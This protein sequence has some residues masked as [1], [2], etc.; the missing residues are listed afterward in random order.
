MSFPV[1][2]GRSQIQGAPSLI[3]NQQQFGEEIPQHFVEWFSG[4]A[5]DTI[6]T[7]TITST[8]T[9]VM[10]DTVD[11]GVINTTA[12]TTADANQYCFNGIQHYSKVGNVMITVF[13]YTDNMTDGILILGII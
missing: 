12:A 10:A 1:M 8:G 3:E 5:L 4:D 6:W 7:K 9:I 11:G 2:W 13:K